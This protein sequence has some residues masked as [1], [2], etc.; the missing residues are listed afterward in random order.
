M[1][2]WCQVDNQRHEGK[3]WSS[4]GASRD[5]SHPTTVLLESPLPSEPG[6]QRWAPAPPPLPGLFPTQSLHLISMP[7]LQPSQGLCT[8]LHQSLTLAIPP[9]CAYRS[10][11]TPAGRTQRTKEGGNAG[12]QAGRSGAQWGRKFPKVK[13]ILRTFFLEGRS[14]S[15]GGT[16]QELPA[17]LQNMSSTRYQH[18]HCGI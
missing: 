17:W 16:Y 15:G 10:L 4:R 12:T 8:Q 3:V 7:F 1:L 14:R 13:E 6:V 11:S 18:E 5:P 9:T 2:Y